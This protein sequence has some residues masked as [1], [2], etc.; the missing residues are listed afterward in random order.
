VQ[1]RIISYDICVFIYE[2]EINLL[3]Q[4]V[5]HYI[6]RTLSIVNDKRNM[7]YLLDDSVKVTAFRSLQ[8]DF[9]RFFTT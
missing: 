4:Q 6:L 3:F 5:V 9:E 2:S 8:E 1:L 7:W